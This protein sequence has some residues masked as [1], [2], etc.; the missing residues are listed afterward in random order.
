MR[1]LALTGQEILSLCDMGECVD[2]VKEGPYLQEKR[3]VDS[4]H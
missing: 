1:V 3:E 4:S 2:C